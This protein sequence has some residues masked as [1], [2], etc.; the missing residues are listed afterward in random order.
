MKMKT[1][2]ESSGNMLVV[3]CQLL[4]V[5]LYTRSECRKVSIDLSK[6]G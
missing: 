6:A 1:E 2:T 4:N 3:S 5:L